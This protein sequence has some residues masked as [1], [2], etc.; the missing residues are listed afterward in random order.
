VESALRIGLAVQ[1]P[2]SC[3][4]ALKGGFGGKT[5][6]ALTGTANPQYKVQLDPLYEHVVYVDPFAA[7][8]IASLKDALDRHPVGIVQLELIQGV[9]GVRAVPDEVVRF[10]DAERARRGY[11]LFVDEVQTGMFRTGPFARS[12]GVGIQPDLMTIG[13]GASDMMFPF[14]ATLYSRAVAER[15]EQVAPGLADERRHKHDYEIGYRT[16]LNALDQAEALKLSE[17]VARSS[18]RL[19]E[20]LKDGLAGSRSVKEVRAFGL[21]I[22]IELDV[23]GWPQRWFRKQAHALY[24]LNLLLNREFPLFLGFC[25]YEPHV[26]KLTPPLTTTPDE[27][28]RLGAALAGTLRKPFWQLLPALC[29]VLGK[30]WLRRLRGAGAHGRSKHEHAA[31]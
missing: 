4:L 14:S 26:L 7:D 2:K 22:A 28:E 17:Q 30:S 25:Q 8:A 16:L 10:L 23:S 31:R 21:L 20:V 5:L 6:F 15:L 13:K 19:A 9:G 12:R 11:L 18:A 24:I 3:V 1:H 29:G 27:V